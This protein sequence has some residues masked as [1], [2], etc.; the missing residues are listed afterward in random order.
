MKRQHSAIL[1]VSTLALSW[2]AMQAVHELGHIATS[3]M[4]GGTVTQVFLCPT[5][6]SYT[7]F[8]EN[9]RPLIVAWMGPIVGSIM[10]LLMLALVRAIH[11]RGWYVFQFFAG[12]C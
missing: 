2:L 12:F 8:D 4:T 9:P 11:M 5:G 6:L 1:I 10:P 7:Q 3:R